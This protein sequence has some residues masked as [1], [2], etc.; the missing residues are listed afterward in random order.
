MYGLPNTRLLAGV[1]IL[2]LLLG[3]CATP[4][5]TRALPDVLP[6][7]LPSAARTLGSDPG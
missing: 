7:G 6:A 1:C 2:A 4:P 5:Q 3:G